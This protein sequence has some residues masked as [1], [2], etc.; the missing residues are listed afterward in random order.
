MRSRDP[1]RVLTTIRRTTAGSLLAAAVGSGVVAVHLAGD[2]AS[3][4]A[5]TKVPDDR[6]VRSEQ[7]PQPEPQ[8]QAPSK[9]RSRPSHHRATT[10]QAPAP[11]QGFQ[12]V[13]PVQPGGGAPQSGSG[14]S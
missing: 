12:P 7:V 1:Q 5:A 10:Q 11:A 8:A 9:A 6:A 14:G 4:A 3:A 13:A 2:H